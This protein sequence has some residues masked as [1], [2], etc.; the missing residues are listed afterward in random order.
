[1]DNE[2]LNLV[3]SPLMNLDHT[4]RYSGTKLV[5]DE[6]LSQHI[7]DTIMMGLKI[8]DHINYLSGDL[9]LIPGVYVMKAVYH[10]LEECITGD[11]PRPLKYYNKDTLKSMKDVADKVAKEFFSAEFHVGSTHYWE[12]DNAK[13]GDEG[14]ILK[15]VDTLVVANKVVKEV[16]M[17][18]NMYMLK[19]AHEVSSYLMELH[20]YTIEYPKFSGESQKYILSLI[21]G[22]ISAMKSILDNHGDCLENLHI[23]KQSMI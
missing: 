1:M 13:S 16:T 7:V 14:Y 22:A 10:D 8:I 11:I 21:E 2:F 20:N 9:I 12:W 6:S 18:N 15:L 4:Y 23:I 5:E 3:S 19:V 17:L